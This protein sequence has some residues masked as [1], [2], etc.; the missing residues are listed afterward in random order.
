VRPGSQDRNYTKV[1]SESHASGQHNSTVR[2]A[3]GRPGRLTGTASRPDA[4]DEHAKARWHAETTSNLPAA[5]NSNRATFLIQVAGNF[6]LRTK[7]RFSRMPCIGKWA[8]WARRTS[9]SDNVGPPPE[10]RWLRS[11]SS[12]CLRN[13]RQPGSEARCQRDSRE[14]PRSG[15]NR[16][17]S[18][19]RRG[20]FAANG[21]GGCLV[22]KRVRGSP[23][24]RPPP[25]RILAIP[26][27]PA[28]TQC[29]TRPA[30]TACR[31][32][33]F[34]HLAGE[35]PGEL[36]TTLTRKWRDARFCILVVS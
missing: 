12:I 20:H 36:G 5:M 26:M 17:G 28:R 27:I 8:E 19:C 13:S 6:G 7:S 35:E 2:R 10:Q 21:K 32:C 18:R 30:Q 9:P 1:T 3:P 34:V 15:V 22:C 14:T 29:T 23:P 11:A 31:C 24:R 16:S 25:R 4:K 33:R